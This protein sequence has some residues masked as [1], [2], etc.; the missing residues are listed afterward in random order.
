ME[1]SELYD[2]PSKK[3]DLL[4]ISHMIFN[5]IPRGKS[6]RKYPQDLQNLYELLK[7]YDNWKL[8]VNHPSL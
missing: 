5:Q 8:I 2:D 4:A 7:S 6:P 3:N 1:V